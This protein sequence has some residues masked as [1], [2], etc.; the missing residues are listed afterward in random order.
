M[1]S[2]LSKNK[3]VKSKIR[4]TQK[5]LNKNYFFFKFKL[6]ARGVLSMF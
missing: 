2:S 3:K 1:N 4:L 5:L 6:K